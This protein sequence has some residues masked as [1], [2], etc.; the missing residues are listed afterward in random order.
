MDNHHDAFD[1]DE[2]GPNKQRKR[3]QQQQQQ[4]EEK[5]E[6]QHQRVILLLDLDC[7]YAQ[8][9]R[10]RLGF[11]DHETCCLALLQWNSCLAVSYPA[12]AFG[13]K[14]GDG[15][16]D[17]HKKSQG[18]CIAVHVP[19]LE[20]PDITNVTATTTT[21]TTTITTRCKLLPFVQIYVQFTGLEGM[22]EYLP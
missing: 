8:C 10:I 9:E 3:K 14:R 15:F 16:E 12:R 17:V 1:C 19:I 2:K 18:K 11:T 21:T 7:F 5:E 6:Q 20:A 4:E 13:I 22:I